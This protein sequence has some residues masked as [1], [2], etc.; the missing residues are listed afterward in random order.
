MDKRDLAYADWKKGMKY[1]EIAEKYDVKLST[2]KSWASRYWKTEKVATKAKKSCNQKRKGCNQENGP[3]APEGNQ[4]AKGNKGGGAPERNQNNYKHGAFAKIYADQLTDEEK[5]LLSEI[6]TDEEM[7]L[8]NQLLMLTLRERRLL[9]RIREFQDGAKQGQTLSRAVSQ[10]SKTYYGDVGNTQGAKPRKKV[11]K[12]EIYESTTT[13]TESVANYIAILEAELTKI[14]R[15]KMQTAKALADYHMNQERLEMERD[16]RS[17]EIE[18][19]SDVE[20]DIYG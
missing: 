20:D 13:E 7:Q 5:E 11:T 14:Q 3:G 12:G 16:K 15:A 6:D 4:N 18:D 17:D 19:I 2:I 8:N 9:N 10:K 1:K